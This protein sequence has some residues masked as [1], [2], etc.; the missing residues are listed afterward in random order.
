MYSR[1][2]RHEE[3]AENEEDIIMMLLTAFAFSKPKDYYIYLF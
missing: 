2:H 1:L 3:H